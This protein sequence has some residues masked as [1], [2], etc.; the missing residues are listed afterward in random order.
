MEIAEHI[1]HLQDDGG[2]LARAAVAAGLDA[3]VPTCPGWDVRDL[4]NHIA[5]VHRWATT[6][7]TTGRRQAP[8]DAEEA[9]IFASVEDSRLIASFQAGPQAQLSAL[10]AAPAGLDC[11]TFMAATSSLAFWARRQ[12][13]ETAIH[14]V[15]AEIAA[16]ENPAC[17]AE[18]ATDGIDE[19][20]NCFWSRPRRRLV[21]DPPVALAVRTND[22]GQAWT[23]RIEPDRRVIRAGADAAA[24]CTVTGAASDLY[25]LLWNR[26]P[27]G[28]RIRVEGDARVLALWRE[29][30]VVR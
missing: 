12:A 22:T 5:G 23:I 19:L 18:L 17:A 10:G 1:A 8:T 13:H 6:I 7:V 29:R 27:A 25:L 24:D 14:R 21:A 30:A 15:D 16:G 3:P 28:E 11:W 2:R 20:L 4:V 26:Q 9:V